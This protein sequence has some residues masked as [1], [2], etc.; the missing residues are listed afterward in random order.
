MYGKGRVYYTTLRFSL[1]YPKN[2]L[3]HR[4]RS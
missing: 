4:K 2:F 3:L 1:F